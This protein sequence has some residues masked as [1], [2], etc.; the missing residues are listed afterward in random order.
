M[1]LSV[2]SVSQPLLFPVVPFFSGQGTICAQQLLEPGCSVPPFAPPPQRIPVPH[3]D[4]ISLL[5][6]HQRD[7][8]VLPAQQ[9]PQRVQPALWRATPG[10][11]AGT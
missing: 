3:T 9:R 10:V 4:L 1:Y 5:R 8:V 2:P 7:S 11:R 6:P